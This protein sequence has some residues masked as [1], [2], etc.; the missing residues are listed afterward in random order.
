VREEEPAGED[1][2][3]DTE[4]ARHRTQH[5]EVLRFRRQHRHAAGDRGER[6]ADHAGAVL[7][8]DDEHT[9][10]RHDR[11]PEDD[12]GQ[13]DLGGV[14][15]APAADVDRARDERAEPGRE[16]DGCQQDPT[17]AG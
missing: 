12:A 3:R 7:L 11:L 1:A 14:L 10:H 13:A 8:G 15:G 9:E 4:G 17:G 6:R 5:D 2:A 16:N